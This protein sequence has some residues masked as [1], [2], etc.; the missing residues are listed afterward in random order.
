VE[1]GGD[2]IKTTPLSVENWFI[3]IMLGFTGVVIGI[4]MRLIPMKEDTQSFFDNKF[5]FV[6]SKDRNVSAESK[7]DSNFPLTEIYSV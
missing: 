7:L 1:L 2:F 4:L 3:T 6:S 5:D